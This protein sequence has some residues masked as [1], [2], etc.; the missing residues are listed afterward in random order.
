MIKLK[1]VYDE[2]IYINK[3][4]ISLILSTKLTANSNSVIYFFSHPIYFKETAEELY[5]KIYA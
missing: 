2:D 3:D 4:S 1:N 5:K